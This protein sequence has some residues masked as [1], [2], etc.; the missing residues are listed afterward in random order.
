MDGK[1]GPFPLVTVAAAT[2][3]V[4]CAACQRV[5]VDESREKRDL[6]DEDDS[7]KSTCGGSSEAWIR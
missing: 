2:E 1:R 5:P 4:I 3:S 7:D 6:E